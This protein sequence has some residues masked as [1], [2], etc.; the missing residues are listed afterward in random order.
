LF[1][2]AQLL[3]GALCSLSSADK[4]RVGELV[5][6]SKVYTSANDVCDDNACTSLET[7]RHCTQQAN[8]AGAEHRAARAWLD[9]GAAT[10]V[11]GDCKRLEQR[12]FFGGQVWRKST[13]ESATFPKEKKTVWWLALVC[14][15]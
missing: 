15:R 4:A 11:Y 6:N 12:A 10:S 13:R 14:P 9:A 1:G 8:G 5:P 3:L 2:H 7:S